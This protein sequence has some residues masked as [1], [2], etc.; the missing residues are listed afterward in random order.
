MFVFAVLTNV[1]MTRESQCPQVVSIKP[2]TQPTPPG[3]HW[4][5]SA[6]FHS[7]GNSSFLTKRIT[8]SQENVFVALFLVKD[9]VY[10]IFVVL[11]KHDPRRRMFYLLCHSSS[12]EWENGSILIAQ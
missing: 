8:F 4:N 3:S 6:M 12:F 1:P 2:P 10:Q 7:L 5:V 9:G 11:K